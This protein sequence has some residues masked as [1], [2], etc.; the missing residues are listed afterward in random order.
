MEGRL[1]TNFSTWF[2]SIHLSPV[3][4]LAT[5]TPLKIGIEY[6]TKASQQSLKE[7]C[8]QQKPRGFV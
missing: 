7:L 8:K 4:I 1:K 2:I 3:L 6:I 5:L